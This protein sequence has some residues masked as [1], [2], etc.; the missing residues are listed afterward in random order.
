MLSQIVPVRLRC[1]PKLRYAVAYGPRADREMVPGEDSHLQRR[2][3]LLVGF[4]NATSGMA[5]KVAPKDI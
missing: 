4:S 1:Q 3:L 5:P 2:L